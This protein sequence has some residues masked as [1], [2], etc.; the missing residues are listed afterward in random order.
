MQPYDEATKE[1]RLARM[2]RR[3][4]GLLA[5]ASLVFI[6]ARLLEP[7]YPWLGFLRATAEASMIGGLADWFAVTALF[8]HPMGIPIPHTAIIPARKDNVGRSL[9]GFVQRNF[10][11]RD[12]VAARLRSLNAA[13]HLAQWISQPE[14]A[15]KIAK[16]AAAGLAG[17]A[18]VLRDEDVQQ[19]IDNILIRR[20]H[21]TRV[22]PLLGK[23]LA[24]MTAGNRHQEL[25]DEVIR[26]TARGVAEHRW[27]IR[28]KIDAESP[29]WVPGAVDEKIHQKI[30]SSLEETLAEV[31]DDPAHPL[32]VRFD[33]A[34]HEFI[35]KL[36]NAPEVMERAEALKE[37]ILNAAVV[38]RFSSSLW[39]DAKDAL[40]RFADDPEVV[41]SGSIERG[42][43]A[44]GEAVLADPALLEKVD[45][46][47]TDMALHLVERYRHEVEALISQTVSSWN[48][49]ATSR[50]IELAI[51]RDLQFI[52]INGTLVGGLAGLFLYSISEL[53][54]VYRITH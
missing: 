30:V 46:V 50:R 8:R 40:F 27:L 47:I 23:I 33:T 42:L 3:A 48:P 20:V 21:D 41:S 18:R 29:W 9:G 10:L 11:S 52:R 15:R 1:A 14:N 6:V 31:R 7:R 37:D 36:H 16:Q 24:I 28:E 25:L 19:L 2:K 54:R 35:E 4:T 13:E 51:G 34:L 5:L 22:A 53:L 12:V 26:I 32:R 43:N 45:H 39:T 44:I 38:Q 49:D 17:A